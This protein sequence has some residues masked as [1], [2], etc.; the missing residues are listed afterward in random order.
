MPTWAFIQ[1]RVRCLN[2]R[3]SV[4]MY[5]NAVRTDCDVI[6]GLFRALIAACESDGIFLYLI[7][8]SCQPLFLSHRTS[9]LRT[10]TVQIDVPDRPNVPDRP[11]KVPS[12][13]LSNVSDRP[14]VTDLSHIKN[15]YQQTISTDPALLTCYTS[16]IYK[17]TISTYLTDPT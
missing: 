9:F 15:I 4:S 3:A 1:A 2:S 5:S 7:S 17:Q 10:G 14:D 13:T 6:L 16:K 11:D 12:Q 8:S